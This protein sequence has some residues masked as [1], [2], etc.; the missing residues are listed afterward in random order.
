MTVRSRAWM[1][2][3]NNPVDDESPSLLEQKNAVF[4]IWQ[5]EKGAQGTEHLQGY[6]IFKTQ[7]TL[8]GLKKF[9]CVDG[10]HWEIR[11]GTHSQA[12]DYCCKEDTRVAGPWSFGVEPADG[13]GGRSDLL[14]LKRLLD[15]NK[16]EMEIADEMFGTWARHYKCVERYKRLK[17][18]HVRTWPSITTVLYGP[19]GT[20]KTKWCLDNG[21]ESAYW[22]KKPNGGSVFFD[23]YEGQDIV[24]IDEFYGWLPFDLLC[25]MCDRYPLLVDTKGGM[26]NFYPKKIYIT[27]NQHPSE[28]YRNGL[29]S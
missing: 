7:K 1:F 9:K 18:M 13:K 20:G 17:N 10:A 28:W 25:R 27:S 11:R 2:T 3:L 15:D 21:G 8:N 12:R 26:C 16:S 5:K 22:L 23:G 29:G 6:V 19:P 4:C 14:A 24:I